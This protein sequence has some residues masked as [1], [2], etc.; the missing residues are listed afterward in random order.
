[1]RILVVEDD[2]DAREMTRLA[3]SMEGHD[4]VGVG[5][6]EDALAALR[7]AAY[8]LVFVDLGLPDMPGIELARVVGGRPP[9]PRLVALTGEDSEHTREACRS[10]GFQAHAVKPVGLDEL[11]AMVRPG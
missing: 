8:D 2:D 9:V 7:L 6:A 4:V 5:N 10:A 3:L 11:L 1:M